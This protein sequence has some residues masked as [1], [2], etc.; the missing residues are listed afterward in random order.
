MK[1]ALGEDVSAEEAERLVASADADGDGL[2]SQEEFL[3]LALAG[4]AAAEE[5]DEGEGERRRELREAFGMYAMEGEGC[6][7]P[8]I[9]KRML[10][11]AR[12][13]T[14]MSAGP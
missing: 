7:M 12:T 11:S 8:V 1:A 13:R 4:T 9:L 6:I 2:L 14:L 5:E 3:A 10:G